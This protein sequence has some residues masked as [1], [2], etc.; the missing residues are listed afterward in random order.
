MKPIPLVDRLS[1]IMPPTQAADSLKLLAFILAA[2]TRA[3]QLRE[4]GP[5]DP[6]MLRELRDQAAA[7]VAEIDAMA[8]PR[9]RLDA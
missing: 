8:G 4:L 6:A 2:Q 7:L 5:L 9:G 1:A 3:R